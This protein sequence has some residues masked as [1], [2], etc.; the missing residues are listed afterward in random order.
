MAFKDVHLP[1]RVFCRR[2]NDHNRLAKQRNVACHRDTRRHDTN[3]LGQD[4]VT[5]HVIEHKRYPVNDVMSNYH[6]FVADRIRRR[7]LVMT[8]LQC[9]GLKYQRL[10]LY[11]ERRNR[12]ECRGQR[13]RFFRRAGNVAPR[14]CTFFLFFCMYL[15]R[16]AA[17]TR[18]GASLLRVRPETPTNVPPKQRLCSSLQEKTSYLLNGRHTSPLQGRRQRQDLYVR[19]P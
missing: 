18:S 19:R 6:K 9:T 2:V 11:P 3:G 5:P 8:T 7:D 1:R 10:T 17:C 16:G 15:R 14:A 13:C 12:R 4:Y